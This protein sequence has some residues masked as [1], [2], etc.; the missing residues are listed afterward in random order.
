MA[1]CFIFDSIFQNIW[2]T[3]VQ[4]LVNLHYLVFNNN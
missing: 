2:Y 1:T 3:Y 4:N